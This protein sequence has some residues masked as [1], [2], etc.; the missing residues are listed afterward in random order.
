MIY[1]LTQADGLFKELLSN[2]GSLSNDT[3]NNE[4]AHRSRCSGRLWGIKIGSSS[5]FQLCH[6]PAENTV[7][8]VPLT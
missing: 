8:S 4:A 3:F 2:R 7:S 6:Y 5:F 1:E